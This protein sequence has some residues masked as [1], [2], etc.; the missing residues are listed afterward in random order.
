MKYI[1]TFEKLNKNI[2]AGIIEIIRNSVDEYTFVDDDDDLDCPFL[3]EIALLHQKEFIEEIY[4]SVKENSV[5]SEEM[6]NIT[7]K[8]FTE[9]YKKL[10]KKAPDT[11]IDGLNKEPKWYQEWMRNY[12]ELDIPDW[13]IEEYEVRKNSKKYNL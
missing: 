12:E 8:D 6:E 2:E 11:I 7:L 13:I 3:T 10:L 9:V 1:K 5:H 4:D